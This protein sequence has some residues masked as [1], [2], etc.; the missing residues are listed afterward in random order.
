ML[1]GYYLQGAPPT[2]VPFKCFGRGTTVAASEKLVKVCEEQSF[3]MLC[4]DGMMFL[5]LPLKD[6]CDTS[7]IAGCLRCMQKDQDLLLNAEKKI[8]PVNMHA[9]RERE[10]QTV[11][12]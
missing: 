8:K 2:A 10:E 5:R 9:C 3:A 4:R 7:F 1:D 11:D 6:D 12:L